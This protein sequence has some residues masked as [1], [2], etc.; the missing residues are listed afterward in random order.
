MGDARL[1]IRVGRHRMLVAGHRGEQPGSISAQ[2]AG[3]DEPA[4][5]GAHVRLRDLLHP[6][7]P[8][9]HLGHSA[10]LA[11]SVQMDGPGLPLGLHARHHGAA[12]SRRSMGAWAG[13]LGRRRSGAVSDD[14]SLA[15]SPRRVSDEANDWW[16]WDTYFAVAFL[17]VV[18]FVLGIERQEPVA[19]RLAVT[20][21]LT[22]MAA[23]YVWFGRR[24]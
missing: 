2:R 8:P 21:L 13:G 9:P 22:A 12:G 15:Q 24:I 20:G 6:H 3:G 17:V 18:G 11:V 16:L 1:G 4:L 7:L 14:I 5:S 23:W 19:E 10:R